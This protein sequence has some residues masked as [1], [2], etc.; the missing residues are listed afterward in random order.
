MGV[1]CLHAKLCTVATETTF[2]NKCLA[3]ISE[4]KILLHTW[5]VGACL[6]VIGGGDHAP[7]EDTKG[8]LH[9]FIHTDCPKT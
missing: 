7:I 6:V 3:V 1:H 2:L 8:K 5:S 4:H 9:A